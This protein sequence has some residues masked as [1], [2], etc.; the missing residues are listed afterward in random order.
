MK[1][2]IVMAFM[3]TLFACIEDKGIKPEEYKKI[4]IK[5]VFSEMI[6]RDQADRVYSGQILSMEGLKA[7]EK[8]YGVKT[9]VSGMNFND[10]ML[11]FGITDNI[12]TRA[13]QLLNQKVMNKYTLDYADT[14]IMYKL[15]MPGDGKKH[16]FVQVF[17]L[18]RM[19]S[20]SHIWVKNIVPDGLSM[21]LDKADQN[22][23]K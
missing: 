6:T 13:F 23:G 14:A 11:V 3:L 8:K 21:T 7:F 1:K 2:I 20:I 5:E 12:S 17:S 18:K 22:E 15:A 4:R 9:R 10:D 19:E 16:S